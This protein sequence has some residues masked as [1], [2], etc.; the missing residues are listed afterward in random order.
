[1]DAAMF[2][3]LELV[4]EFDTCNGWAGEGMK[5]CARWLNWKCG[6]N[7][8]A[9]R[10]RVRV[11][12][13]LPGLPKTSELF[14]QG[15]LSF[16]KVRAITRVA[17]PKNEEVLLNIARHGTAWHVERAVSAWRRELRLQ[18]LQKD[19]QRH[20][21]R[22]LRWHWDDEGF[23]V[24][25]ARLTP[26]Q[27]AIFQQAIETG[28]QQLF[29]EQKDVSAE[30]WN[31]RSEPEII[32]RPH[33]MASRRADALVRISENWL[34][35]KSA[36]CANQMVV[37]LHTDIETLKALGSGAE[38][39]L[40]CGAETVGKVSAETSRRIACDAGL[41]HWLEH[42]D[43]AGKPQTLNIGRKS[44]IVSP[45]LRRALQRRDRGCRFPG[46]NCIRFVDAHHIHHWADGGETNLENLVLLCRAHHRLLHEGGFQLNKLPGGKIQ[47][48]NPEGTVIPEAPNSRF[49][50][51]FLELEIGNAGAGVEINSKTAIPHW[52]GEGMDLDIVVHGLL[53]RQDCP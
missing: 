17:T 6:L 21:H 28:A 40:E 39:T 9:A 2:R 1:M 44:R 50:R 14:Q 26:E 4:R 22:E 27:G 48:I 8:G 7:L 51:N 16:S 25:Q 12:H 43:Q 46:C 13:A 30:T 19:N 37:N 33:P 32:S 3:W 52:G 47:F 20:A 35:G 42:H 38:S 34:A 41:I 5:S 10:E 36:S 31:Q 24:A 15:R 23:L 45:A 18:A 29:E 53:L 11:A 49:R